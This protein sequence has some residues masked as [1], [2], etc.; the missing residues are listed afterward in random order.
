MGYVSQI[1]RR[2]RKVKEKDF[3]DLSTLTFNGDKENLGSRKNDIG[4][5]NKFIPIM[6]EDFI[7]ILQ[8]WFYVDLHV[9]VELTKQGK[10]TVTFTRPQELFIE[11]FYTADL[12]KKVFSEKSIIRL[13]PQ[14]E[15]KGLANARFASQVE[16]YAALG[17][18]DVKLE[19]TLMGGARKWARTGAY[20]D[21]EAT[22]P[23]KLDRIRRNLKAKLEAFKK[24]GAIDEEKYH[25]MMPFTDLKNPD[26]LVQMVKRDFVISSPLITREGVHIS[27]EF[28]KALSDYR[29]KNPVAADK[30]TPSAY[31]EQQ[32]GYLLS[33][34]NRAA[35]KQRPVKFTQFG[36]V[37]EHYNA[38]VHLDDEAQM[39][40]VGWNVGGWK[41]G[42][43]EPPK[44][45]L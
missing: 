9:D 16:L 12:S 20:I 17:A 15:G 40:A 1:Q 19:A 7:N 18:R 14:H 38:V 28:V 26:D 44:Q 22:D 23:H 8:D 3:E 33:I 41:S 6:P 42:A 35:P 36:L 39:Q 45:A 5:W 37:F 27:R 4:L 25:E 32:A 30:E 34:W 31:A 11:A 2:T 43:V 13:F 10:L 24:T 29:E 21:F